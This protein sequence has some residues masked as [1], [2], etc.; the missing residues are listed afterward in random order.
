MLKVLT[1]GLLTTVQDAGRP[2]FAPLG[3]PQAGACDP[4]AAAAANLLVGNLPAAPV[5]EITL[6]GPELLAE[7]ACTIGLAGADLGATLDGEQALAPG[8]SYVLRTGSVLAFRGP[9]RGLRA[10][11]ALAGG[12]GAPLVLGAHATYGPGGFG[13]ID[14]TGRPL[15][16]GD[17]LAPAQSSTVPLAHAGRT[18][19]ASPADPA[20]AAAPT[21]RVLPGPHAA[22]FAPGAWEALCTAA[23]EVTPQSDRMGVRL[24][25][26]VL[27]RSALG[28]GELLS[29]G[30]PWGAL[31]VPPDGQPIL[32]LADHQTVGGYPVIGV[33]ARA[34][35]PLAAQA[36]PGS[37]LRFQPCTLAAAQSA[38]RAQATAQTEAAHRLGRAQAAD[39]LMLAGWAGA[40]PDGLPAGSGG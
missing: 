7:S 22:S 1:P 23:W 35:W 28:Q 8:G 16:P 9:G 17:R 32:L 5:L 13:G 15:H 34:D 29:Q 33:V 24:R 2:A 11:L 26:P 31:Q 37:T 40:L 18:W 6:V 19:P 21:L 3:V 30:V 20:Y 10:Y 38:W 14:G 4:W 25:G 36:A 12:I 39:P 27:E